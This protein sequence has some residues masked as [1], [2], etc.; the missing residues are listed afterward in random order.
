MKPQCQVLSGQPSSSR[1]STLV[2]AT[3]EL[4]QR[5]S[6]PVGIEGNRIIP[7]LSNR[8]RK[9]LLQQRQSCRAGCYCTCHDDV[10]ILG[11]RMP[12]IPDCRRTTRVGHIVL[13]SASVFQRL[14]APHAGFQWLLAPYALGSY[15]LV[16]E[17]HEA[18][19]CARRGD[20]AGLRDCFR[21]GE[22]TVSDTTQHL[23]GL[24]HVSIFHA[25]S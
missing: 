24:L 7:V 23:W 10:T 5:S 18:M 20:E 11:F 25:L 19:A 3:R 2:G 14:G 13:W 6:P 12:C 16:P 9:I 21:R 17:D 22:V 15:R 4:P 8:M 1:C